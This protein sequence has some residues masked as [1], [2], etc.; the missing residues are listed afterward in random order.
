[1]R[2]IIKKG[3]ILLCFNLF[4]PIV[5]LSQITLND[6]EAKTTA[7]IFLEHA[8]LSEEN[9][10]LKQQI[11]SLENLNQLYEKSDSIKTQEINIYKDKV[12]SNENKIK[13]LKSTQKKLIAGSSVGGIILFIIGLIL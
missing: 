8:K 10:L 4:L 9:P 6:S 7:L 1:M 2:N 12:V 11:F 13:K 3:L 5:A